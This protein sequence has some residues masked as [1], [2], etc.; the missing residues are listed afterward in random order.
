[1]AARALLLSLL[2]RQCLLLK[3]NGFRERYP[4]GWLVWEAGEWNVPDVGEELGTTRLPLSDVA[5]C[6]PQSDVLCFEVAP[7]PPG[8]VLKVGRGAENDVVINDATVSREHLEV[9]FDGERCWARPLAEASETSV[10]G[11][12]MDRIHKTPLITGV[13]L[14]VGGVALTYHSPDSF[15]ARVMAHAEKLQ[16]AAAQRSS[17][18]A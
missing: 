16:K 1:M 18:T 15:G 10:N 13:R 5:D 3:A 7:P 11:V 2:S 9:G 4:H 8:T 14:V 17:A 6:L 12:P